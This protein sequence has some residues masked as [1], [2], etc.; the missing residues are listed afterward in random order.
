MTTRRLFLSALGVAVAVAAAPAHGLVP[1]IP[2]DR[3]VVGELVVL[4]EETSP[5]PEGGYVLRWLV[6]RNGRH[7]YAACL[8]AD[9]RNLDLV[10]GARQSM[11]ECVNV[12]FRQLEFP[13]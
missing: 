4:C 9:L 7:A 12:F 11:R 8:V 6:A 5:H 3:S 2:K 10:E 13:L 1:R